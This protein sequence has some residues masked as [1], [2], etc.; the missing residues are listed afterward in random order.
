MASSGLELFADLDELAQIAPFDEVHDQKRNIAARDDFVNRHDVRVAQRCPHLS[1]AQESLGLDRIVGKTPAKHLDGTNLAGVAMRRAV[2][3]GERAAADQVEDFEVAVEETGPIAAHQAFGLVI[4][5]QF[6]SFEQLAK[7]VA[8]HLAA[9]DRT[10]NFLELT[11]IEQI[12]VEH[13]L[14][15]LFGRQLDHGTRFP[16]IEIKTP[17]SQSAAPARAQR[18]SAVQGAPRFL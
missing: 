6:A 4:G 11:L 15:D 12:E 5:Q 1:F 14:G 8:R 18:A 9:A 3:P 2:D 10:P 7:L 16:G 13:T 17:E